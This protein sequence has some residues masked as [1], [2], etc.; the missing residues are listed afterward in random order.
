MLIK[1]HRA[2]SAQEEETVFESVEEEPADAQ[3]ENESEAPA[4]EDTPEESEENK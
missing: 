4:K 3:T 2:S 1:K